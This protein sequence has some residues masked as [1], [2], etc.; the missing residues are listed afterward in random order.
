MSKPTPGATSCGPHGPGLYHPVE[1]HLTPAQFRTLVTG[2]RSPYVVA[3]RR[4]LDQYS[5][6]TPNVDSKFAMKG[7]SRSL[8]S[9]PFMP[10]NVE[11]NIFG[12]QRLAIQFKSSYAATYT[13]W[14][15]HQSSG[16]YAIYGWD[17]TLCTPQ[18]QRWLAITLHQL[19]NIPEAWVG[20]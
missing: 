17:R 19:H 4:L 3:L 9:Q 8:V 2:Y 15:Y 10:L 18:E 5:H 16:S 6:G 7:V 13:A 11:R 1:L 12:G 14:V 20:N